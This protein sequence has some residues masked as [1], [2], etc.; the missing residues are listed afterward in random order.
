MTYSTGGHTT[1]RNRYE[2][3]WITKCRYKVFTTEIRLRIREITRQ[4][5]EQLVVKIIEGI[6]SNNHINMF[7]EIPSKLSVSDFMSRVK[8]FTFRKIQ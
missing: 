2:I 5:C 3:T 6:L 1:Y 4:I 8:G 7:V